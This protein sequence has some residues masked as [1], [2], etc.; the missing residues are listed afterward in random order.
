[1]SIEAML[2]KIP[3]L[4]P[5]GMKLED[6]NGG[7]VSVRMPFRREVT[8]H[9]GTMHAAALFAVAE[10]AAGV[11][12][13]GVVAGGAAIPLLRGASIRYA[14]RVDGDVV[15]RARVTDQACD[16]ARSAFEQSARA[17]IDVNVT[18][19]G[20]DGEPVFQGTFDYALRPARP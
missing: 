9:V 6:L 17:D 19:A 12:A 13:W 5:H 16:A 7:E 1:M 3:F 18:V 4:A 2:E 20:A 10:T 14:R 15:A 11:G 8:N